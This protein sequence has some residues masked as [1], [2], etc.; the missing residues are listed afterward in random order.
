[1]LA[2]WHSNPTDALNAELFSQVSDVGTEARGPVDGMEIR[3]NIIVIKH[4][5]KCKGVP[6]ENSSSSSLIPHVP[7][8]YGVD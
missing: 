6:S 1:M 4:T 3:S 2:A 5:M 7:A 8:K